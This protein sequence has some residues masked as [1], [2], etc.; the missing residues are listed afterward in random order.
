MQA[1]LR[2]VVVAGLVG[3][4]AG[5]AHATWSILIVNTRTGEMGVASATCLFGLD[6]R[7]LTPLLVTDLGGVTAQSY[8]DGTGQNRTFIRDRML[9]GYTPTEILDLLSVFD[10]GHETRQY[11]MVDIHGG[12][13]TFSGSMDGQWAGGLTGQVGDLVYCVQGNVLTGEPVVTMAEQAII[14]TPGDLPEKLM[15]AMEAAA[16]MGGDGRC[17]CNSGDPEGCGS[18]PPS[19]DK[20]AHVGYMLVSRPGDFSAANG[21]YGM[22]DD[23]GAIAVADL[24]LDGRPDVIAARQFSGDVHMFRNVTPP[25]GQFT[26][27]EPAGTLDGPNQPA[28]MVVADVTGDSIDDILMLCQ[29]ADTIRVYQGDGVGGLAAV[30]DVSPGNLGTAHDLQLGLGGLV[31][32]GSHDV[33]VL[34]PS[35]DF[36]ATAQATLTGELV[37]FAADPADASSGF[38]ANTTGR[39]S[40]IVLAGSSITVESTIELAVD[41]ASIVADDFN[42]DGLTDLFAVSTNAKQADLLLN[43]GIGGYARQSYPLGRLGRD[44]L[45]ADF[46]GDGDLDPAAFT[47]GRANLFIVRNDTNTSFSIEPEVPITRAPLMAVTDDLTGDGLPEVVT[48]GPEALGVVIADNIGGRFAELLGTAGGD[49]FMQLNVANTSIADPDPVLLLREQFDLWRADMIGQVDAVQSSTQMDALAVPAGSGR[50]VVL[51]ITLRDWQGD[52]VAGEVNLRIEAAEGSDGVG[53]VESIEN[54]GG[55]RYRA[56]IQPGAAAG[57][58]TLNVIADAGERTVILTPRPIFVVSDSAGDFDGDGVISFYDVQAFL[59]AFATG[60]LAADLTGDGSLD[61]FDVQMF[62][63]ALGI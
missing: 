32:I 27:L 19:F 60:D 20:S 22:T 45:V 16:A 5:S 41:V 24:D 7:E 26:M 13:A 29:E 35:A 38:V 63:N 57:R 46:D 14:S 25:G 6:L 30:R 11:G 53:T 2:S 23:P 39:I 31:V 48:G 10:A 44:A 61:F 56:T 34:D 52:A 37:S 18:P 28:A 62:L 4:A 55:G 17:S 54:L 33:Y 50:D 43:D 3:A 8:G 12:V 21:V 40:R 42:A 47:H 51:N 1:R 9:E 15:A 49:F 58:D 36:A 59:T